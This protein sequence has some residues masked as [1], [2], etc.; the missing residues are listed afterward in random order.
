[1]VWKRGFFVF[2]VYFSSMMLLLLILWP[3]TWSWDYLWTLY[4]ISSYNSWDAWQHILTGL[5]QSVLLQILPFPGGIILLQ[6]AIIAVCVAFTVTK[7]EISFH[8]GRLKNSVVDMIVKILP[9]LMPPVLM[10]QF[11]G[12]RMGVYVYL[13]LVMLIMLICSAKDEKAWS[14]PYLLTFTVLC[15]IV[16]TWRTESFVYVPCTFLLILFISKNIISNKRKLLCIAILVIGFV[17]INKYQNLQLGNSNYEII[18]LMRPCTELVRIADPEEDASELTVIDK[19]T[20]LEVIQNNP[21]LNGEALYWNTDCVRNRNDNPDDDY[22]D[23]DYHNYLKAFIKLSLKYPKVVIAERWN[24]FIEG[25]GITGE[26]SNNVAWT[27]SIFDENNGL[28]A[29]QATLEKDG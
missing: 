7:L 15:T 23:E 28:S 25:S 9:F 3:D 29:A 12:Y 22:T 20:N 16:S 21:T 19:V 5:F 11:S 18:S 14:L 17:G 10:Y 4:H 1:M 26:T 2:K 13:E 6:N 27:S 8:I 24:L